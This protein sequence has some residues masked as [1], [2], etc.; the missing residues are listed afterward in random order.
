MGEATKLQQN[1]IYYHYDMVAMAQCT[2][3]VCFA[4]ILCASFLNLQK[5]CTNCSMTCKG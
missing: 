5:L 1:N 2:C 3:T 4:F